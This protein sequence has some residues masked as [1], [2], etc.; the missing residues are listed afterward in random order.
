MMIA[1]FSPYGSTVAPESVAREHNFMVKVL[2]F[3]VC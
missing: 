2:A 3:V 1:S